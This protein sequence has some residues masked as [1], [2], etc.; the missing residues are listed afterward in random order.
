[1]KIDYKDTSEL[2]EG[3]KEILQGI[4]EEYIP[5]IDLNE[6]IIDV[7]VASKGGKRKRYTI[8]LNSKDYHAR[9]EDWDLRRTLHSALK[10]IIKEIKHKEKR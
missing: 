8:I 5:K 7:K 3:E 9:A 2:T 6:L 10:K 1:M 4:T